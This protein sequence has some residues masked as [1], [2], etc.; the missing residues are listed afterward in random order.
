MNKQKPVSNNDFYATLYILVSKM[1]RKY[2][3]YK[4]KGIILK[5]LNRSDN[6]KIHIQTE[7]I[8]FALYLC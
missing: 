2:Q 4:E 1:S 8:L 5:N 7:D 6:E 3:T